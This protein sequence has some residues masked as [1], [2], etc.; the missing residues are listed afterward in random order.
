MKISMRRVIAA[1]LLSA[2]LGTGVASA[3]CYYCGFLYTCYRT[4]YVWGYGYTYLM[5][6][7]NQDVSG[8]SYFDRVDCY[9]TQA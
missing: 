3:Q 6:T 4:V 7:F 9:A 5:G 8:V 2:T 1:L